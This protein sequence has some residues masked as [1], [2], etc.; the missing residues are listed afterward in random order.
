MA[1]QFEPFECMMTHSTCYEN[2]TTQKVS[3]VLWHST[4]ANNDMLKRYVQ[5]YEGDKDYDKKLAKLGVNKSKND[6]NH[7]YKKAG[8]NNWI[9]KF[10]DGSV[11]T[12][13]AMPW[14]YRPWGCGTRYKNGPSCNDGWIQFEICEEF[15]QKKVL[16]DGRITWVHYKNTPGDY[17]Y[18]TQVWNEA[19]RFTAWICQKYNLDPMG[20]VKKKNYYGKMVDVPVILDHRGAWELGFGSGHGDVEHWFK[21]VLGKTMA[22]ARKEVK[23]LIDADKSTGY[24][25][26]TTYQVV[27]K[28]LNVRTAATT[29][30][31]VVRVAK[32]GERFVCKSSTR[33]ADKIWMRIDEGW[34]CC[35]EGTDVYVAY[36][37]WLKK[38]NKW[39]YY[40]EDGLLATDE[41]IKTNG[42]WYYVGSDGVML[43]G[44]QTI[45]EKTYYL[46][47]GNDGHMAKNEWI[48]GLWLGKDG[49][50]TYP[51]KG[52]WKSNN[53][54]KWWEDTSG[55]YPKAKTERIDKVDYAFDSK[56]YLI[57]PVKA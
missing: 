9:G 27:C 20:T 8:L 14:N 16:S 17:E 35:Q 36:V 31:S 1:I 42:K 23:A 29:K 4:G 6:W 32:K 13:Q 7:I 51:Y 19:V 45:D 21:V 47:P 52:E 43:T 46:Y 2:T 37:G 26:G 15:L 33:D 44:W 49:S 54:G 40:D 57:G 38:D 5:P 22:D 53:K 25:D 30:S 41:W 28:E 12:V 24:V 3:G 34:I 18:A 48:D 39:Y 55:Y 56:G 50:Q 10:A 11:G